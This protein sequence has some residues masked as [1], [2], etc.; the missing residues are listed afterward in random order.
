MKG[1]TFS[2]SRAV[3]AYP[4]SKVA[5]VILVRVSTQFQKESGLGIA[6][7]V[8]TCKEFAKNQGIEGCEVVFENGVSGGLEID[9]RPE[10]LKAINLLGRG[11]SLIVYKLDRIARNPMSA[12]IVDR[13]VEKKGAKILSADG[14]GN[15]NSPEAALMKSIVMAFACYE[16]SLAKVRTKAAI[17][18]LRKS[19]RRFSRRA[20]WGF[21]YEDGLMVEDA[22]EQ[23]AIAITSKLR[24]EGFGWKVIS[25]ELAQGGFTNRKGQPM[26][27]NHLRMAFVRKE[28]AAA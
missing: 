1:I 19:G 20:P 3:V 27:P 14:V 24:E 8:E 13:L 16:R 12:A 28:K 2:S 5:N 6:A 22:K 17:N 15:D 26:T 21:R 4:R 23:E 18:T 7:Q 10:L 25:Q 9:Q 11:D